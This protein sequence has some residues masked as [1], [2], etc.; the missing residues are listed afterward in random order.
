MTDHT[1]RLR[2]PWL[3]VDPEAPDAPP[4]R[5]TLPADAPPE[6]PGPLLRLRRSFAR[7]PRI[8]GPIDC[9][10]IV[11]DLP[12]LRSAVLNGQDLPFDRDPL[13]APRTVE[14]GP[15]LRPRN[16][17]E[18]LVDRTVPTQSRGPWGRIALVFG[19]TDGPLA[20]D[21]TPRDGA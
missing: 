6:R 4:G 3:L 10:L 16:V 2:G 18:L 12:G 11:D 8:D 20:I 19:P 14:I 7:P 17:L 9:R 5:L 21:D 13:V 1:I 15:L